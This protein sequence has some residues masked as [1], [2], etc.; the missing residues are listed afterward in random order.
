M[1]KVK[2]KEKVLICQYEEKALSF[3]AGKN[4]NL[5][6]GCVAQLESPSYTKDAGSIPNQGMYKHQPMNA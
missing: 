5:S 2:T 4:S 3:T 1:I 6:P